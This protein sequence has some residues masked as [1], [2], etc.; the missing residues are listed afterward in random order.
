M[1]SK[2]RM[3]WHKVVPGYVDLQIASL[4]G[5]PEELSRLNSQL[6]QDGISFV[7]MKKSVAVRIQVPPMD[8]RGDFAAQ[9]ES[10]ILALKAALILLTLSPLI[11]ID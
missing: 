8:V 9:R 7:G 3:I 11:V 2:G 10:A 5:R 4:G 1:L 6:L